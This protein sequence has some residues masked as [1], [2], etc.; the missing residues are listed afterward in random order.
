MSDITIKLTNL[1]PAYSRDGNTK[2]LAEF[3]LEIGEAVR[4]RRMRL[5]TAPGQ[6]HAVLMPRSAGATAVTIFDNQVRTAVQRAA[7]ELYREQRE[8]T[9]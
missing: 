5:A 8:V 4:L 6:V 2:T 9:A 1:R 3:D 7:V